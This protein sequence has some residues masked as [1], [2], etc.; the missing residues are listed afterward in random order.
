M[1]ITFANAALERRIESWEVLENTETLLDWYIRYDVS[2]LP[3]AT[4][5]PIRSPR[6]S[7]PHWALKV[8]GQIC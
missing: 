2:A 6:V 5:G 1:D 8:L 4:R 3:A 7:G